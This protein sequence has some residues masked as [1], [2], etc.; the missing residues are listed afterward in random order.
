M[1]DGFLDFTTTVVNLAY[2][3]CFVSA[4]IRERRGKLADLIRACQGY[5]LAVAL[6]AMAFVLNVLSIPHDGWVGPLISAGTF[7]A[8]SACA[9][10][11]ERKR[12]R[13]V[14]EEQARDLRGPS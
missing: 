4:M 12:D 5:W 11:T 10:M 13:K 7:A 3:V 6:A 1:S 8:A 14:I 9:V 2:I